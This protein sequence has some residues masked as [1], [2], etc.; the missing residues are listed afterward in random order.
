MTDTY[1]NPDLTVG[2]DNKQRWNAPAYRRH[3]FHNAHTIFKRTAMVRASD[4]WS[5]DDG[6]PTPLSDMP[7]V[8]ELVGHSAFSALVCA[9]D[10][11][12]LLDVSAQDFGTDQPH[13]IQSVTKMHIHLIVGLLVSQGLL[14]LDKTVD[15][16][17]PG[18]GT[19]YAGATI[20]QLLDMDLVNDFSE[21]YEDPL[22][23][24]YAEEAA[25]GWRLPPAGEAAPA[26][27]DFVC[28]ITAEALENSSDEAQYKSANTDVLTLICARVS[29]RALM[30][31]VEEIAE[32][33]GYAGG[34]HISHSSDQMPAFSG[35]GCLSARDLARFGL[36]LCRLNQGASPAFGDAGFLQGSLGRTAPKLAP[37]RDWV[38]YSNH[39]MTDGAFVG[40]AGYGGQ[41]LMA[42][43]ETGVVAALLSV[44]ENDAGYDDEYMGRLVRHL[45][46]I[47]TAAA[48]L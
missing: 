14:D 36:M 35:G 17:L 16:Y 6:A 47:C 11:R 43:L 13:S 27:L 29:P 19:G 44:L 42:N 28:G 30:S 12:L 4:I 25:L 34:F 3:G 2:S 1:P 45:K 46:T 15:Q 48:D 39:L 21:D 9:R 22:S 38:R 20:Q 8:Q 10:N 7:E 23:D 24:C 26:L 37:P 5:L 41:F 31:L 32:A 33:A 18:I 40:H